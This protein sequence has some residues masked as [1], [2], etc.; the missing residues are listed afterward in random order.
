MRISIWGRDIMG[1]G[2]V[3]EVQN[4]HA[5]G[6]AQCHRNCRCAM[7]SAVPLGDEKF[8]QTSLTKAI[9]LTQPTY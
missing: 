3:P 1:I 8:M 7:G 9:E 5:E 6:T 2:G 4:V